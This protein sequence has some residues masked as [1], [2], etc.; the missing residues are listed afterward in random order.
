M[1]LT[2][3]QLKEIIREELL[4]LDEAAPKMKVKPG[5]KQVKALV[6]NLE[7]LKSIDISS[8]HSS[9]LFKSIKKAQKAVSDIGQ[10]IKMSS[11]L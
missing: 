8:R 4:N 7:Q 10:V 3:S 1:K 9:S 5:E 2:K 11:K 6:R